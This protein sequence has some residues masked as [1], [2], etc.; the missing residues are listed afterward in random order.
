MCVNACEETV[1]IEYTTGS[2]ESEKYYVAVCSGC[3]LVFFAVQMC[4][5]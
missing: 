5:V 3:I 4:Y 1:T 2:V